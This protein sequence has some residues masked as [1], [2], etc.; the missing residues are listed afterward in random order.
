MLFTLLFPVQGPHELDIVPWARDHLDV[1]TPWL[2]DKPLSPDG[3]LMQCSVF[4]PLPR[5]LPR[6][7][8]LF[9]V[10]F[11]SGF[12]RLEASATP[13]SAPYLSIP[14]A[15]LGISLGAV[16]PYILIGTQLVRPHPWFSIAVTFGWGLMQCSGFAPLPRGLP[17]CSWFPGSDYELG[18]LVTR[19]L[20]GLPPVWLRFGRWQA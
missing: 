1:R 7:V 3:G 10:F 9:Q 6:I 4:A 18:A 2:S 14:R 5:G 20:G 19:E 13:G 12:Y 8:H 15:T 17:T 11:F 16:H